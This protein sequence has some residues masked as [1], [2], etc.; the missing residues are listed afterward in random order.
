MEHSRERER[1]RDEKYKYS[2]IGMEDRVDI[3]TNAL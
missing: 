1:Q 3:L 2:L